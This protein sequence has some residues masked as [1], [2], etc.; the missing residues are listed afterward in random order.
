MN[1]EY[2][3]NGKVIQDIEPHVGDHLILHHSAKVRG[4]RY[5]VN[6]LCSDN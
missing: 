4:Q 2:Q 3:I 1:T 6:K 5:L